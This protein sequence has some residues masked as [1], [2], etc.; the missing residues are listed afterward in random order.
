MKQPYKFFFRFSKEQRKGVLLLFTL[1]IIFQCIYFILNSIDFGFQNESSKEKERWLSLQHEIDSLK[2]EKKT[3]DD[4]IFP[5]NPNYISDYKGYVL[6]LSIEEIDRLQKYRKKGKFVNTPQE[7]KAVTGISDSILL[8]LTPYFRFPENFKTTSYSKNRDAVV[9]KKHKKKT[10]IVIDINKA[11]EEDLIRVYGIGPYFAKKI[12]KRRAQLG[13]FVSMEQMADFTR[14]MPH[15][16]EGLKQQFAVLS[17]PS[18][19]KLNINSASLNQLAYFPYFNKELARSII[20]RRSMLGKIT[21]IEELLEINGF[22]A[23]K[24]KII[25]LYLEF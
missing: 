16:L 18:P 5:F 25:T 20:T 4:T 3:K 19:L 13:A 22:P 14:L 6:G 2:L 11:T 21:K 9:S 15:A 10:I 1:I 7:F 23:E 17:V 8:K 12:V 24:E